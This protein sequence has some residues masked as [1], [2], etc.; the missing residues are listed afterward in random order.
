MKLSTL[1]SSR[2]ELLR[3]AHLANLALAHET[4]RGFARRIAAAGLR[5]ELVLQPAAP[6]EGRYCATLTAFASSQSVVEE[7]FTE[8]DLMDLA[9]FL[10]LALGRTAGDP[11]D[12]AFRGERFVETFLHPLRAEL[13]AAGVALDEDATTD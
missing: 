5:G 11:R 4:L 6:E 10:C 9:D 13:E 7:H 1:I 12:I 8:E 3:R 2:E